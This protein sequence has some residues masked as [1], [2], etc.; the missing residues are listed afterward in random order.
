MFS[1]RGY[2]HRNGKQSSLHSER[3][4]SGGLKHSHYF[5]GTANPK[6]METKVIFSILSALGVT[7]YVGAIILN[8][9]NWKA[10]VLWFIACMFGVVK[11]I[12]YCL[13]TWQ[14]YRRTEIDIKL[15]RK[16]AD[17]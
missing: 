12:R 15:K 2:F 3:A 8:I 11:F 4:I 5:N 14:D 13:K 10:D 6:R 17:K 1:G 7:S 16:E 9:G